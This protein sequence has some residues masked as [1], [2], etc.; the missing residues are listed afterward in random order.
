MRC[1]EPLAVCAHGWL[2]LVARRILGGGEVD[3]SKWPILGSCLAVPAYPPLERGVS[4]PVVEAESGKDGVIPSS[5]FP[6]VRYLAKR[7]ETPKRLPPHSAQHMGSTTRT[8][9]A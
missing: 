7:R 3:K 2:A 1:S 6:G 9:G 5:Q 4:R 8:H